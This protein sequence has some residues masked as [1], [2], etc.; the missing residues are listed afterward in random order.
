MP[1][2]ALLLL[3]LLLLGACSARSAPGLTTAGA[4]D[5]L[6][7]E[8]AGFHK[9]RPDETAG[10]GL[11]A[12]FANPNR[13]SASIHALPPTARG[14]ARDGEDGPEVSAAVEVF[15]RA[16][17]VDAASRRENATLRHFGARVAEAGPAARCLDVQVRGEIPRRQLGC[18]AMLERRV[19]V[20]TVVAPE[21][22]EPRNGARDPLLAVTMRLLGALSGQP[23]GV[24]PGSAEPALPLPAA[25]PP[26]PPRR[27][28]LPPP[29]LL[30]PAYRT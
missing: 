12:R 30:G 18:A 16:T 19:F 21:T 17:I 13:A 15:A 4:F 28:P 6:P 5:R 10:S 23:P 9:T 25:S 24:G 29:V 11:V 14:D 7:D 27:A 8:I 20:V 2:R 3:A 1:S 22:V 26:P